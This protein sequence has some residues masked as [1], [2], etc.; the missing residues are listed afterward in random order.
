MKVFIC[1]FSNEN[2]KDIEEKVGKLVSREKK[3]A[4]NNPRV[5][6]FE[7]QIHK[8]LESAGVSS[9]VF[10]DYDRLD[11]EDEP[12]WEKVYQLSD[13]LYSSTEQDDALKY[14]GINF[15][16]LEHEPASYV[17]AVR[18]SNILRRMVEQNCK[19][20]IIVLPKRHPGWICN[21]NSP[22]VKIIKYDNAVKSFITWLYQ[23]LKY[24]SSPILRGPFILL[25]AYFKRLVTRGHHASTQASSQKRQRVL[26]VVSTPLYAR[27]ALAIYDQCLRDGLIPHVAT[28]NRV[29]V[30]LWQSH[31][32]GYSVK[33]L[34]IF[35]L[36]SLAQRAGKFLSL[37]YRLK[38]HV[39]LFFESKH[40]DAMLDEFSAACLCKQTLLDC[41]PQLCYEAV[42]DI[43]FLEKVINMTSPDIICVM[44]HN[45]YL[46]Q[47]ASALA[48]K[49]NIPTLF[50]SA[51]WETGTAPSFRRH[52]HA[53]KMA[54]SG[55]KMRD[56][57][58]ASGLEP[59][60]VFA[61]GI[62][63]F[64]ILFNRNVEQD[65]QAL[66]E[67]SIDPSKSIIVFATQPAPTG[68]ME[69][70]LVGIIDAVLKIK[71]M[72]LVIK[73]H[74]REKVEL[75][76][77]IAGR[78][79]N[80]RIQVVRDIGLY[81]LIS[82]CEL[83]ITKHSNVGLEAMMIDKP[84]VTINLYGE[85]GTIPSYAEAGAAI[86]VY[87]YQ[88]IEQAILDAL[89]D[90]ETRSRLKAGRDEYVR[91]WAGEPDGKASQRIVTLMKE[92][93]VTSEKQRGLHAVGQS[94]E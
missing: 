70:I 1:E 65:R 30:P 8:R 75:Y 91:N 85:S 19:V 63:H 67:N 20:L 44:P 41:L 17:L 18:F 88:D 94:R 53:D 80:A 87:R 66:L 49:R 56:M 59:E 34:F 31:H 4:G 64:D 27:P 73:V 46:Q 68:E 45:L 86:G 12:S 48:K 81:A 10:D 50:C 84:V 29:L 90:E 28:D 76:Q 39:N 11:N 37:L 89:Y 61:T 40:P 23:H 15:L 7:E 24:Q 26:F 69:E 78:Y 32:I 47:M 13:E 5:V 72:Q 92:M 33:P 43:T 79:H 54:T 52:L 51:A 38:K 42:T 60:R 58:I 93:I 57:Y 62:A 35:S 6:C 9:E 16:T 25:K 21:M 77:E 55:K 2:E 3:R 36:I 82:N 22:N 74:P 83:L 14:S 71:D